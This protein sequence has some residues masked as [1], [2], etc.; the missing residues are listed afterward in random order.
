MSP[1]TSKQFQEIREEKMDL[2]MNAALEHFAGEGYYRTTISHIA[3]HAG[4]SKGLMYNYFESKEELLKAII[5]RS[6]NEVY[7]DIDLDRDGSLSEEEFVA[8]IFKIFGLLTEKKLF[9][10]L[11]TQLLMQNDVRKIFVHAFPVSDGQGSA[12]HGTEQ[13]FYLPQVMKLFV[14]Y[15]S[16]KKDKMPDSYDPYLDFEFFSATLKGAALSIIF[17]D[18]DDP[19]KRNW[20][21]SR[22]IDIFK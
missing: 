9:W 11:L 12:G 21:M 22:I 5:H 16:G 8:F 4:I 7:Q 13:D 3:R 15:F 6:I 19:E 1:R 17:A 2:I 20:L 10:R 18:N 14:N